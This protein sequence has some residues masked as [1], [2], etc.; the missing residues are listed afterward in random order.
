M[1]TLCF[2]KKASELCRQGETLARNWHNS[3]EHSQSY[4]EAI[5]FRQHAYVV[6]FS[7]IALSFSGEYYTLSI[8]SHSNG[9]SAFITQEISTKLS[10]FK[11]SSNFSRSSIIDTLSQSPGLVG[12]P[13]QTILDVSSILKR[14]APDTR[15]QAFNYQY[16]LLFCSLFLSQD[17]DNNQQEL[18]AAKD[19]LLSI[20]PESTHVVSS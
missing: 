5:R 18:K 6:S 9:V 3:T 14:T 20:S 7:P 2:S 12:V 11:F 19:K 10:A 4:G 13:R 8:S 15:F 16:V 1:P 17:L